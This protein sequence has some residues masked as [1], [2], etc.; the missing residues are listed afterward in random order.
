MRDDKT[1]SAASTAGPPPAEAVLSW[2]EWQW[3][4]VSTRISERL[5]EILILASEIRAE[6]QSDVAALLTWMV[7]EIE[8]VVERTDEAL[9]R[10]A[11]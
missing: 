1:F 8:R 5:G 10:L 3:L 6:L 2:L 4:P 7:P 11:S 9:Q